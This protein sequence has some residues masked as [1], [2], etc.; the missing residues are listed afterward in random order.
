MKLI[1]TATPL[2]KN[3]HLSPKNPIYSFSFFRSTLDQLK[4]VRQSRNHYYLLRWYHGI[5]IAIIIRECASMLRG[6]SF[7]KTTNKSKL[8]DNVPCYS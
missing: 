3:V 5:D 4:D 7:K 8:L 2:I 6:A 1:F